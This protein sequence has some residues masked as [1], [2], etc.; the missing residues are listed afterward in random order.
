MVRRECSGTGAGLS[1]TGPV[2]VARS[3]ALVT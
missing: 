1:E 3:T 2:P